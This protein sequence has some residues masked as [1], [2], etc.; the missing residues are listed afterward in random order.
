M[1]TTEAVKLY[2]YGFLEKDCSRM[3]GKSSPMGVLDTSLSPV[4]GSHIIPLSRTNPFEDDDIFISA[5]FNF[6]NATRPE[7][8]KERP[9]FRNC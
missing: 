7:Q 2:D 8:T 5:T 4:S 3:H 1:Q 6:Q 9:C